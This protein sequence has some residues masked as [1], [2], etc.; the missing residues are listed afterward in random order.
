MDSTLAYEQGSSVIPHRAYGY[1]RDGEG[2]KRTDQ[3]LTSSVLGDGGIY[4]CVPDLAKWN[5]ALFANKLIPAKLQAEAFTPHI[6]TDKPGVGYG[7][8]WYIG[9]YRGLKEIYH[10][11][12][13]RGFTTRNFRIPEKRFCVIILTNRNDAPVKDLPNRLADVF[14]FPSQ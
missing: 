9:E 7:Y 12:E 3:S 13:S 4:S 6:Q 2:W 11:G 10:G 14:L 5:E 1:S 8:G